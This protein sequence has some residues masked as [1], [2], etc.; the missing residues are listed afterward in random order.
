[1]F[2]A[3]L[4]LAFS[5]EQVQSLSTETA[6]A[7]AMRGSTLPSSRLHPLVLQSHHPNVSVW[8]F[9][10]NVYPMVFFLFFVFFSMLNNE[11]NM[12]NIGKGF[13]SSAYARFFLT[14]LVIFSL[15]QNLV[16]QRNWKTLLLTLKRHLQ[17]SHFN[18]MGE[19][20]PMTI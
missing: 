10:F 2:L 4:M 13:L 3:I 14:Y 8:I 1:M 7:S 15:Q 5:L 17:V 19:P 20:T 16:T 9:I 12:E 6:S 18:A 11:C